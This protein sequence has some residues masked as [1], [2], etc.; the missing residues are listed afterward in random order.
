MG[1]ITGLLQY[2]QISLV[3]ALCLLVPAM[4]QAELALAVQP[5]APKA[6]DPTFYQDFADSLTEV[7]GEKVTY[8][9][10]K[11]WN[12]FRK[13][14]MANDYDLLIAE[15]H[16]TA[17]MTLNTGNGGLD[18]SVLAAVPDEISYKVVAPAAAEL[19]DLA[20]LNGKRV[21][22]P[23]SP[24][25]AAVVFLN[26]YKDDPVN[27]PAVVGSKRGAEQSYQSMMNKRCDAM[28]LTGPELEKL[29]ITVEDITLVYESREFP[30][31]ALSINAVQ[32]SERRTL[33]TDLL[34]AMELPTVQSLYQSL[35]QQ[36]GGFVDKKKSDFVDYNILPGV[37]WGW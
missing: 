26:Q 2:T 11:S 15:P 28:V 25:L 1:K 17:L 6:D 23:V 20:Q 13:N 10:E 37:V 34:V 12:K 14:L 33:I 3:G 32:P 22:T 30:G 31:W 16:I 18:Y 9:P 24:G 27:P 19:K 7:L 8:L 36:S 29:K 4:G 35:S 21:C 5:N